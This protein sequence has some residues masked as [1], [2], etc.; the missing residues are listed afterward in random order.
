VVCFSVYLPGVLPNE[1]RGNQ[2][3]DLF[4]NTVR[5]SS[6]LIPYSYF[7][8]PVCRPSTLV[9][10]SASQ[11]LGRAISGSAP[12]NSLYEIYALHQVWPICKTLCGP[13][14]QAVRNMTNEEIRVLSTLISERYEAEWIVDNMPV[15]HQMEA[16][17]LE[18]RKF[19]VQSPYV[20]LGR[21]STSLEFVAS[22]N[23][24]VPMNMLYNHHKFTISYQRTRKR[25]IR[26]IGVRVE[27]RS[28]KH[29]LTFTESSDPREFPLTCW[30]HLAAV[31][32][33]LL[34]TSAPWM[35]V[36][37]TYSVHWVAE[38]ELSWQRRYD[39]L[40]RETDW[41]SHWFGLF[42]GLLIMVPFSIVMGAVFFRTCRKM[43]RLNVEE[44][45]EQSGWKLLHGDVFRPPVR[46]DLYAALSGSGLQML[47]L[48]GLVSVFAMMGMLAPPNRGSMMTAIVVLYVLLGLVGGFFAGSLYRQFA[49]TRTL[50][51]MAYVL[52][53][54]P[55]VVLA[56][57]FAC[58]MIL[59]EHASSAGLS[60]P[61]VG[62]AFGL[63][64]VYS[65]LALVGLFVGG[66]LPVTPFPTSVNNIPRFIPK[67][68]WY[69]NR[70]LVFLCSGIIPFAVF[71]IELYY[72]LQSIWMGQWI[73]TFGFVF[74][75]ILFLTLA[76]A[77]SSIMSVFL[78]LRTECYHWWWR[79][80]VNGTSPALFIYI[81]MLYFIRY[82]KLMSLASLA[83][84]LLYSTLFGCAFAVYLGGVGMIANY[85]FVTSIYQA[86]PSLD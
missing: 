2:R 38:T 49:G 57:F 37:W 34:N 72:I 79:A 8:L 13:L 81:Y 3:I 54:V 9:L 43:P 42:S 64:A 83:I 4:V 21:L 44:E 17:N 25:G 77:F 28:I 74:L 50:R 66:R 55:G 16:V 40:F 19:V 69:N 61:M 18:G 12:F 5:S 10:D 32:P 73:P 70:F 59:W 52:F 23:A 1:Y 71:W 26:V 22:R 24:S 78:R 51:M 75:A 35:E 56:F 53:L 45:I 39:P 68:P 58:N 15:V 86:L 60:A 84:Y 36:V 30:E 31:E 76:T 33:L 63:W 80:F 46:T 85:Y 67:Q 20:P 7:S 62:A 14:K 27:P 11:N 41:E 82:L 29:S 48:M 47:M 65:V 6:T